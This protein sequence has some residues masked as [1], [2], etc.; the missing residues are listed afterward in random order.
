MNVL[1]NSPPL[2]FFLF[3]FLISAAQVPGEFRPCPEPEVVKRLLKN[4]LNAIQSI[5][6]RF[7]QEKDNPI[8]AKP[9]TAAG[10]FCF[11]RPDKIRW[12]YQKP[13]TWLF[14]LQNQELY[15]S[16][17]GQDV[18][19][20]PQQKRWFTTMAGSVIRMIQSG[21]L[22]NPDY[23]H[24]FFCDPGGRILVRLKPRNSRV[25]RYIREIHLYFPPGGGAMERID[26]L[27]NPEGV[28]RLFFED[29]SINPTVSEDCFF[30]P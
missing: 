1:R 18:T 27:E 9:Q 13:Y 16:E 6:A 17:N 25:A 24:S 22:E 10:I 14:I 30:K 8:L 7:R 3:K 20:S 23:E 15:R 2:L 4:Q 29:Q 12:E 28:T 26:M 5:R 19:T 11:S 21:M